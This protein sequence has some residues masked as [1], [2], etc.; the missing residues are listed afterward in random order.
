MTNHP[1]RKKPITVT[2]ADGGATVYCGHDFVEAAEAVALW[3]YNADA[4]ASR[5]VRT[6]RT[7]TQWD[8]LNSSAKQILS[9]GRVYPSTPGPRH[10]RFSTRLY[11]QF[12]SDFQTST[13]ENR[14]MFHG[15]TEAALQQ[16]TAWRYLDA[17]AYHSSRRLT[18]DMPSYRAVAPWY[19]K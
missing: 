7:V 12:D 1:N 4:P 3:V 15:E 8:D 11:G 19:P 5:R 14:D 6:A 9:D 13:I 2:E 16:R 18:L 10:M 17:I